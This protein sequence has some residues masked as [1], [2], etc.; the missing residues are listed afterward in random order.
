MNVLVTR[1]GERGSQLV[2]LLRERGVFAMHQPLFN[3]EK[4]R[5]L[6]QLPF[7]LSRL[8]S[9]DYV[10]PV[11]RYAVD[12]ANNALKETGFSW[13]SDLCYF[14]VGQGTANYFCAQIEQPVRYPIQSENS[15]GVLLLPEMRELQGKQ[16]VILRADIGRELLV[17]QTVLRGAELHIIECYRRVLTENLSEQLSLVKR[18]SIDTIIVTSGEILSILVEQVSENEQHW[19][20]SC[21]LIVVGQRIAQKAIQLGWEKERILVSERADNQCLLEFCCRANLK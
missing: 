6:S 11:S 18:A 20:K 17:E 16:I 4:G 14:A 2:E 12:F 19:L 1:P 9:G 5:E 7:V 15:E 21:R 8:N 13:R 10:F 3:V